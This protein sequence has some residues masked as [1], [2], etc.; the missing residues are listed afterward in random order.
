M[1]VQDTQMRTNVFYVNISLKTSFAVVENAFLGNKIPCITI[2]MLV[3]C[4]Y[5]KDSCTT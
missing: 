3:I 1:A 2:S 5:V 4:I